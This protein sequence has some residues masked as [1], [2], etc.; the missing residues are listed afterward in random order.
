MALTYADITAGGTSVQLDDGTHTSVYVQNL[1]NRHCVILPNGPRLAAGETATVP[2][3]Q[4]VPMTVESLNGTTIGYQVGSST[5]PVSAT[6]VPLDPSVAAPVG[7][8]AYGVGVRA[9]VTTFP[10]PSFRPTTANTVIALDVMPNG[11]PGA[12]IKAWIDVCDTD[13]L[14]AA[15]TPAVRTAYLY[16]D[17]AAVRLASKA[18]GGGTALPLWLEVPTGTAGSLA[19]AIKMQVATGGVAA[20]DDANTITI[21]P[22]IVIAAH[23]GSVVAGSGFR[24]RAAA[25]LGFLNIPRVNGT[26]TGVPIAYGK[27]N[28]IAFDETSNKLWAYSYTAA[29]WK[30]VT[31]A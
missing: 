8:Q 18:L 4:N 22:Y 16:L 21:D 9:A 23:G 11:T 31:L 3:T 20:V 7:A 10:V 30:S 17:G 1:G 14:A 27:T 28:P 25:T 13:I 2:G 26:P 29:A 24:L 5:W 19:Q 12:G 15:G 6:Y